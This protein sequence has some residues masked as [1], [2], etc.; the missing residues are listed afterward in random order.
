MVKG[1]RARAVALSILGALFLGAGCLPLAMAPELVVTR[2]LAFLTLFFFGPVTLIYLRSALRDQVRLLVDKAGIND[3]TLGFGTI[4]W[5]EICRVEL[6]TV[7][8]RLSSFILIELHDPE[9]Y[10]AHQAPL[11]RW[12]L[13]LIGT[14]NRL[15]GYPPFSINLAGTDV[16]GPTV[17]ARIQA[18]RLPLLPPVEE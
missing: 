8:P 7:D 6:F 18:H 15:M 10:L 17:L 1:S 12:H 4:P 14:L 13:R 16:D 11:W 2:V 9:R 5:H 3:F